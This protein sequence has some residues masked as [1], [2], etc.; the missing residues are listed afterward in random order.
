VVIAG[1][2]V[3]HSV[4]SPGVRVRQGAVVDGA[5]VMEGTIIG[6]GAVVRRAILDKHVIVPDGAEIGVDHVADR[7]RG[8]TVSSGGIVVLGKGQQIPNP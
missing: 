6:A 5:V 4:F 7:E 3:E 2:V 8:F 1:A